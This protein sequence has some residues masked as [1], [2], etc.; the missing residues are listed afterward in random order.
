MAVNETARGQI[1]TF[2]SYK[3]GTGRTMALA[4]VAWILASQGLQ[5]LVVDWDLESP[6]LHR[7][8]HPFLRDKE[9]RATPGVIEMIWD[10]SIAT[11]Q[12]NRD[13]D[14]Q[15]LLTGHAKI[16][17]RA[18]SL[19]WDFSHGGVIDF[20]AAGQQD[21]AYSR[22]VSTFDWANF[23]ER[24]GGASFIDAVRAQMRA[25]YDVVLIDSRTGLSDVAGI[26]TVQLPDLVVNCFTM[27]TPEHPRC[28]GGGPLHPAAS[29]RRTLRCC[30]R[31]RCASR[32]PSSA[33]SRPAGTWSARSSR[34]SS[35]ISP[36]R[37]RPAT[38][39][40]SRCPTGPFYA[41]E[42]ILATFGDRPLQ[43]G[44]LLAATSDS[45]G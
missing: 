12:R 1:V 38:G 32:T 45:S 35:T 5:V 27:S 29:A 14:S 2:Y 42:E 9:L 33:S 21:S 7:Y 28:G 8:F 23:Y 37:P 11:M 15:E 25:E 22:L 44:S 20:V 16:Q 34:R 40:R 36:T 17:R 43:V 31:C 4:N 13:E 19:N 18:V 6:G 10:Y 39:T 26:C 30:C 24:Q 3:G 41:Y